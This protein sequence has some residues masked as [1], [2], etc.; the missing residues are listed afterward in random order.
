M[1]EVWNELIAD[2]AVQTVTLEAGHIRT[3]LARKLIT[4]A[5]SG[6]SAIQIK[7]LLLRT[8]R[9]TIVA[10][11]AQF[12]LEGGGASGD[13]PAKLRDRAGVI[14]RDVL[15]ISGSFR[16]FGKLLRLKY[17]VARL[18]PIRIKVNVQFGSQQS[19]G[20]RSVR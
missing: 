12:N 14:M 11:A 19:G 6:W 13:R 2:E 3:R 7:Q 17:L 5:S 1:D 4:F 20:N 9:A 8:S 16:F 18:P 10:E 15:R